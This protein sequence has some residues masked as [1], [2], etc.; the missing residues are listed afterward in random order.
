MNFLRNWCFFVVQIDKIK[1]NSLY[2][3]FK[4]FTVVK[5]KILQSVIFRTWSNQILLSNTN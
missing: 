3:K 2:K 5:G 1:K 4:V